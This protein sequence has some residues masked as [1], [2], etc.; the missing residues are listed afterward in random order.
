MGLRKDH[1]YV[2][3]RGRENQDFKWW[4]DQPFEGQQE[5]EL[6]FSFKE[7][8]KKSYAASGQASHPAPGPEPV[9]AYHAASPSIESMCSEPKSMSLL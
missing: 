4:L 2:C 6:P 1:C 9:S 7:Q 3:S 5:K 8:G